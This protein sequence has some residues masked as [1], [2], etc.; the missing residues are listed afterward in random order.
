M[1]T[2]HTLTLI[3]AGKKRR[4]AATPGALLSE[5]LQSDGLAMEMPCGGKGICKKCLVKI[6]G[7]PALACQTRI[8]GNITVSLNRDSAYLPK[9]VPPPRIAPAEAPL[10]SKWGLSADIGTTTIH[11]TLLGPQENV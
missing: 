5:L 10:Y 7:V 8:Q 2:T 1:T 4:L 9:L 11:M 3:G 6:N